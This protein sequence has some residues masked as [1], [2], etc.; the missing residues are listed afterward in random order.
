LAT[1]KN[2]YY[3]T[4]RHWSQALS[5]GR[6]FV[7]YK[8]EKLVPGKVYSNPT[9][10]LV[11]VGITSRYKMA[12]RTPPAVQPVGPVDAISTSSKHQPVLTFFQAV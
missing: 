4:T 1:C 7:W 10:I 12:L 9:G 8:V 2:E 6:N 5:T 3:Y 11:P